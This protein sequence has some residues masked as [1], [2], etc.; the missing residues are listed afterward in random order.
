MKEE[1]F[2]LLLSETN[3]SFEGWDFSYITDTGRMQSEPLSWCYTSEILGDLRKTTSL[4]DMGTGGGEYLAKLIPLPALT[5]A[6]EGYAPNV[7]IAKNRLE[8][9]HVQVY[10]VID[11]EHLPLPSSHF[12]M[13]INKHESF[14]PSEVNRILQ[15]QGVFY[16]QQVGGLDMIQLNDA[17]GA[18]AEHMYST[19]NL[20]SACAQ[21]EEAGFVIE[22]SAE[23]FPY[24]RFYD[25]G[26]IIY[27]LKAILWQIPDFTVE[28]YR[29]PLEK[30]HQTIQE[31]GYIQFQSH[32]FF[33]Q[34]RKK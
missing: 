12:E 22:R 10:E 18:N 33:L 13:I 11:D 24:A 4:L 1:L 9:L 34:A 29:D 19:W 20:A 6:T 15:P 25:V 21:L 17:L 14:S 16:T 23:A 2:E 5:C 27:Y 32:R 7:P 28:K 31:N 8:P 30:F 26:A 3:R